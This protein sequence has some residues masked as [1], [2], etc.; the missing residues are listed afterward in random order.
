[1]AKKN[2]IKTVMSHRSGETSDDTIAD[3]AVGWGCDFIKTGIYGKTR[4][5]KLERLISI[6]REL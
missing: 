1:L 5:I 2:N 4:R 3:L 6:E